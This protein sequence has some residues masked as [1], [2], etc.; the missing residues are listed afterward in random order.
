MQTDF[1]RLD[2]L[3][4]RSP[5]LLVLLASFVSLMLCSSSKSSPVTT[6]E[7]AANLLQQLPS[8]ASKN[9]SDNNRYNIS[10]NGLVALI[11]VVARW[12][13]VH[14]NNRIIVDTI[15]SE[16]AE[17][18]YGHDHDHHQNQRH[19][20]Q[21]QPDQSQLQ[22]QQQQRVLHRHQHQREQDGLISSSSASLLWFF[23]VLCLL[24]VSS[25][26]GVVRANDREGQQNQ[27][28]GGRGGPRD[29]EYDGEVVKHRRPRLQGVPL[30][31]LAVQRAITQ[32]V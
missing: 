20:Q 28:R 18:N 9:R 21:Q 3:S 30:M 5:C 23:F 16:V 25:P 22:H 1:D 24:E 17:D 7:A 26:C 12:S 19:H 14:N 27:P 2:G 6:S 29:Q 31:R 4:S 32:T 15:C 13:S 8:S 10:V 11:V